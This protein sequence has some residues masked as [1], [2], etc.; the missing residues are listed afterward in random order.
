MN[1]SI[2]DPFQLSRKGSRSVQDPEKVECN[3]DLELLRSVPD[4]VWKKMYAHRKIL[5]NP[6][7]SNCA[8][9]RGIKRD[10]N[11][12]SSAGFLGRFGC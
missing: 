9:N 10:D 4:H 8:L 2:P 3:P 11:Q 5:K 6:A 1:R 12:M 7:V